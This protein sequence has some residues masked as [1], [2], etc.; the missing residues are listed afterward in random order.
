M[1]RG[2]REEVL[3]LAEYGNRYCLALWLFFGTFLLVYGE[4]LFR[5]WINP[6]FADNSAVLLPIML[7][8]YTLWL[9]QFTSG[10]ILT[11]SPNIRT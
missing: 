9:G 8:G 11:G 3:T 7:F 6:E 2:Y 10:A 4:P 5:V 1:A